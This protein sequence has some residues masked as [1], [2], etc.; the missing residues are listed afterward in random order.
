MTDRAWIEGMARLKACCR[1]RELD[2]GVRALR[3]TRYRENLN[4]QT[5][6]Q[7]LHA[8]TVCE[9]GEWFPS[10]D[11]LLKTGAEIPAATRTAIADHGFVPRS[12]QDRINAEGLRKCR[13]ELAKHG[14]HLGNG[15]RTMPGKVA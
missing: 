11:S 3:A 13:E 9:M 8:V 14:I 10:I 2:D 7:F 4:H 1:D 12:E 15:A 6:A 5:D